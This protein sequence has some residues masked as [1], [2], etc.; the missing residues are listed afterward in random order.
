[1]GDQCD[2]DRA[3]AAE[4]LGRNAVDLAPRCRRDEHGAA[5]LLLSQARDD[6]REPGAT[7]QPEA[8]RLA[9]ADAGDAGVVEAGLTSG[10][11]A[12]A[13]V[14]G[15]VVGGLAEDEAEVGDQVAH[16]CQ[17]AEHHHDRR[18]TAQDQHRH[19][20]PLELVLVDR[21]RPLDGAEG[22][23]DEAEGGTG[24]DHPRRRQGREADPAEVEGEHDPAVRRPL[25]PVVGP[26]VGRGRHP[27]QA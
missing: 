12:P 5:L 2:G 17:D 8:E 22:L 16:H 23:G 27:Q 3:A 21:R 11:Q 25:D 9:D 19:A 18:Q 13:Q 7:G 4:D 1:V 6:R 15:A 10:E 26:V 24:D 14:P 20:E